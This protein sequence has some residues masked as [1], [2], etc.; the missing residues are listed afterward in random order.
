MSKRNLGINLTI[1]G[2]VLINLVWFFSAPNPQD[3]NGTSNPLNL[4]GFVSVVVGIIF[5]VRNPK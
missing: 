3:P 4:L 1:F 5:W 2:V